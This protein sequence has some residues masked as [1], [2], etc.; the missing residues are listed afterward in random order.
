MDDALTPLTSD[1][2]SNVGRTYTVRHVDRYLDEA[3]RRHPAL[4]LTGPRACGKTT[5]ALRRV[6]ST[7]RLD[8]PRQRSAFGGSP[9]AYLERLTPPVLLD[10]WQESPDSM[11]AVKRAVDSGAPAGSL[12]VTGSVRARRTGQTWP[13]TGRVVPVRMWGLT[14]AERLGLTGASSVIDRF[15]SGEE[16]SP[17]PGTLDTFD[18]VA[19]A[20]KGGFPEALT[21][22]ETGRDEWFDGYANQLI[23]RDAT[24]LADVRAPGRLMALVKAL[25]LNTAGSPTV[26]TLIEASGANGRTVARYLD[27][28]TDLCVIERLPAWGTGRTARL[29]KAPRVHMA[30]T[31]LAMW[32]AGVSAEGVLR[33]GDLLGRVIESFV[34]A[35]LRP[36]LPLSRTRPTAYHLRDATQRREVDIVLEGRDGAIVGIE[37]KAATTATPSDAKHLR[38]LQQL[39]GDSF[40]QGLVLHTGPL[41]YPLG[42]GIWAAP[43]STIWT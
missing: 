3:A 13:G 40:K 19:E 43:I 41:T 17:E 31:G 14:M 20:A 8:D 6:R 32:L 10:E 7:I 9:D 42:E 16:P 39:T 11:S 34:M 23:G 28:L 37:V 36:L 2:A 21:L 4:M 5:T 27:L 18:Y 30:D 24:E 29:H 38:W 12:F 35:Q 26:A 33:D 1:N 25:A 22:D 15:M